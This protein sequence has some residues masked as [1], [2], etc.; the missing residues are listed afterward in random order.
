MRM[1]T[2]AT[3]MVKFVKRNETIYK[4][5]FKRHAIQQNDIQRQQ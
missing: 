5:V 3:W 4:E 2:S 1:F